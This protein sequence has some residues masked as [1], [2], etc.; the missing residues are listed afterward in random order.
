[1]NLKLYTFILKSKFL[2][3]APDFDPVAV[4]NYD[5]VWMRIPYMITDNVPLP[6]KS[7]K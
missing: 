7:K 2:R 4:A 6:K 3:S 5:G 1:V